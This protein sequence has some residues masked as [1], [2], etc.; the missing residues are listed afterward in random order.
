MLDKYI[1]I[2]IY[3][4]ICVSLIIVLYVLKRNHYPFTPLTE[5][6]KS[7][8]KKYG[9]VHFTSSYRKDIIEQSKNLKS[10]DSL[11]GK[12]KRSAMYR[13]EKGLIWFYSGKNKFKDLG[14]KSQRILHKRECEFECR[15]TDISDEDLNRITYRKKDLAFVYRGTIDISRIKIERISFDR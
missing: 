6:L 12:L 11:S 4:V 5:N 2:S 7:E 1:E 13:A 9:L 10:G 14:D 3:A 15:F 8:I